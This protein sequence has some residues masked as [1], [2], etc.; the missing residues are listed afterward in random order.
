MPEDRSEILD[1]ATDVSSFRGASTKVSAASSGH[2]G[3]SG[4]HTRPDVLSELAHYSVIR[5]LGR[6]GMGV[7]YL[8]HD[9]TLDRHVAIKTF[10]AECNE[11]LITLLTAEARISGKLDHPAIVP[12][13]EVNA[14][15]DNPYYTMA[16]VE[17]E[18]LAQR[19][20]RQVL[21]PESTARLGAVVADALHHAHLADVLHLDIKP[22]NILLDKS[23]NAKVT[24][25]GLFALLASA[26]PTDGIVGTPQFMAPEQALNDTDK[27]G[28]CSDIYSLGAVLYAAVVGRPPI[29]AS[30]DTEL[31][32]KVASTR[33][34]PLSQFALHIPA[35]L[36]AI[37]MKCLEKEPE[38][39]Y[40]SAADLHADLTAYLAGKPIVARP[41][42]RLSRLRF[43]AQQHLFAASVSGSLVLLLLVFTVASMLFQAVENHYEV[44][45]LKEEVRTLEKLQAQLRIA[46]RKSLDSSVSSQA[47][48]STI[49]DVSQIAAELA[50]Q[51]DLRR[52]AVFAADAFLAGTKHGIAPT[53]EVLTIIREFREEWDS[54]VTTDLQKA[55]IIHAE[56]EKQLAALGG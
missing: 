10:L 5:E 31:L 7:V 12:V 37:I 15:C 4:V 50:V 42:G 40:A 19:I 48:L 32:L 11:D 22:A 21:S 26:K 43:F 39:R 14:N 56:H 28:A 16:Y 6:G 8:A 25:F 34:K 33:P 54:E 44:K 13:F 20:A 53:D 24:D 1:A 17:G 35:A 41:C 45:R 47:D 55:Q 29:V 38:K 46:H 23:E 52:A 2:C 36:D 27:I 49:D 30:N 18:N 51:G 3:H 9:R